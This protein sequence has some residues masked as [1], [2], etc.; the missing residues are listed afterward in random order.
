MAPAVTP[1]INPN[2]AAQGLELLLDT[3]MRRDLEL[4]TYASQPVYADS[5]DEADSES[6]I[7]EAFRCGDGPGVFLKM[8]N[9][10]EA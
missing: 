7:V 3:A 2:D 9:F 5:E 10:S 8:A 1:P 6:P 4:A